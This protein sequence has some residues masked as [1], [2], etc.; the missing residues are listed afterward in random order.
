[1]ACPDCG[2]FVSLCHQS[3]SADQRIFVWE[4]RPVI[5]LEND[6]KELTLD[7]IRNVLFNVLCSVSEKSVTNCTETEAPSL[8]FSSISQHENAF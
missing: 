6:D 5:L 7:F 4:Y 2:H 8:P 3:T 1:M